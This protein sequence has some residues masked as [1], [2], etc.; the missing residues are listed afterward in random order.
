MTIEKKTPFTS[1]LVVNQLDLLGRKDVG[2]ELASS[3][4]W[5]VSHQVPEIKLGNPRSMSEERRTMNNLATFRQGLIH[6]CSALIAAAE[7]MV[8][9]HNPH[10]LALISRGHVESTAQLGFFCDRL[11]SLIRGKITFDTFSLQLGEAL[12]SATHKQF[13]QAPKPINIL[14]CLERADRRLRRIDDS[15][16]EPILAD[17]YSWLSDFCHPNFLSAATAYDLD[18]QNGIMRFRHTDEL[19]ERDVGLLTYLSI[20][21]STFKIFFDDMNELEKTALPK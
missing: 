21:A 8:V 18:A 11:Y 14:T 5:L 9:G 4:D 17:C 7:A 1:A 2:E 19:S 10:G 16:D 6:R 20:S 3:Y 15:F 12:I 13:P